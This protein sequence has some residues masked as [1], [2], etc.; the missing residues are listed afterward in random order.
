MFD[1]KMKLTDEELEILNGSQGATMAK[2]MQTIVMFGEIFGANELIPITHLNGHLATSFGI[3]TLKP[4]FTIVE[5]L[6]DDE[7]QTKGPFT[8]NPRPLDYENIKCNI[9]EKYAF[10]KVLYNKQSL[11]EEELA[12]LGLKDKNAFT[13]TNYLD[14]VGNKPKYGD[15]LSWSESSSVIYAN[16]VIGARSNRNSSILE[17]F[18]NILGLVPYYGLL[19]DEGRKAKTK[20]SL[21]LSTLVDPQILGEVVARYAKDEIVYIVGLDK[22]LG[23]ELNDRAKCYLKDFGA[24]LAASSD[25]GLYHIDNL[26]PEA[27]KFDNKLLVKDYKTIIINDDIVNKVAID[28]AKKNDAETK[29]PEICF[30]GCPHLTLAQLNDWT[31]KIV[32]GLKNMQAKKVVIRTILLTSPDVLDKFKDTINYDLLMNMGVKISCICPMMY[33]NNPFTYKK[34]IITN[35]NK[36]RVNS[37]SRY[38]SNDDILNIII[39]KEDSNER[40]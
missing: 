40:V 24:S 8:V 27:K 2:V 6:I 1:Y 37:H 32:D 11:Y 31:K 26:T 38:Y 13:C 36:L 16:S 3:G 4:S 35:S 28:M 9:F 19:L 12:K 21:R 29:K 39:G 33:T 25:T 20:I 17:L 23:K 14:E 34:A 10:S 22:F 18:G 5:K 30:I 7:I 15:I